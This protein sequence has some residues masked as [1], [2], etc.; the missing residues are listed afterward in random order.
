MRV[1]FKIGDKIAVLDDV[2]KGIVYS[3]DNEMITIETEDEFLLVYNASDLVILEA[4]QKE[5][6]KFIDITHD[7][8]LEKEQSS[9]KKKSVQHQKKRQQPPMEVDL[10]IH[11]LVKSTKGMEKHDLLTLQ[12]DTAKRQL[13]FAIKKRIQRVVFIHGV[14]KGVLQNELEFLLARYPVDVRQ[15]SFQKYGFGAIEVYIYQNY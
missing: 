2:I 1:H 11:H 14:G 15:A 12:I 5:L 4:D 7:D 3:I 6:S 8:L 13:E 10:H 9:I